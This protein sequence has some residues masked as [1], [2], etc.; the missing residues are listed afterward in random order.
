MADRRL[1]LVWDAQADMSPF[2]T[3]L[4]AAGR[5]PE[6]ASGLALAYADMPPAAREKLVEV[7]AND[8]NALVLLLGVERDPALAQAIADALRASSAQPSEARDAAFAWGDGQTGGVGIVRRLHG[9]FVD[10]LRVSWTPDAVDAQVLPIGVAT[11]LDALRRRAAIPAEARPVPREHAVDEMTEALWR[12]HRAG[13]PI[14][15][16]VHA[17]AELFTPARRP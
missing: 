12:H 14:P 1:E 8:P 16:D 4:E 3:L 7:L 10:T 17:F 6:A 2:D 9:D 13:R 11:D 15:R 5:D